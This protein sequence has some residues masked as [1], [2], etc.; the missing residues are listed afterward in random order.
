MNGIV[1]ERVMKKGID[2]KGK[3]RENLKVYDVYYRFQD[4]STGVWKQTSKKGFRTKGEAESFL[5]KINTQLASHSFVQPDKVTL[6]EYLTEWFNEYEINL[7]KTTVAG[8]RV[9]IEKHIIPAIGNV[10][11]QNL[12]SNCIDDFYRQKLKNGRVDGKG[13]LSQKSLMYI[14][15]VLSLALDHAVKKRIIFKNPVKEII[16][17][18]K[19]LKYRGEVYGATEIKH[20]LDV[21]KNTDMELPIALAAVCGMRR[22]EVMGL[23]HTDIDLKNY[24]INICRQLIPTKDGPIFD[25]PKTEDSNRIIHFPDGVAKIIRRHLKRQEEYKEMLGDEYNDNDLIN[26]YPNGKLINPSNFSKMFSDCLKRAGMKHITYHSLR[27]A[28][29]SL[30]L[31]AGVEMKIA[32]SVLGHSS[33]GITADLYSHVVKS[34]KVIAAN[35]VGIVIFDE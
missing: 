31:L 17:V 23:L 14:H 27:H 29:A 34:S 3:T 22:G 4:P 16:N 10:E 6:R 1:R 13:G 28:A 2:N 7:K 12:T 5:L 33:L 15:R 20:L 19:P 32:S 26:C 25:T 8:Y 11:M 9:N 21:V 30:M 24:T 35:K 18:P